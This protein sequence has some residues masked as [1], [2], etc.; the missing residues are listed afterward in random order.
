MSEVEDWVGLHTITN[1]MEGGTPEPGGRGVTWPTRPT[2]TRLTTAY[3]IIVINSKGK[4]TTM[5]GN[6]S[7]IIDAIYTTTITSFTTT[8]TTTTT[9]TFTTTTIT[10]TFTTTTTTFTTTTT[11]TFT[12]TTTTITFTTT[13]I[14]TTDRSLVILYEEN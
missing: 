13:T 6:V 10:T 9:T 5:C 7:I 2:L 3:L 12:T 14:T 4:P 11:T 1:R 8:T